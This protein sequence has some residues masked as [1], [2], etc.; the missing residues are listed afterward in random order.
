MSFAQGPPSFIVLAVV[1]ASAFF[2]GYLSADYAQAIG[3]L[4]LSQTTCL[5][6]D[7]ELLFGMP[8]PISGLPENL[9]AFFLFAFVV[10]FMFGI[11]ACLAG[12][13]LG[14]R[15]ETKLAFQKWREHKNQDSKDSPDKTLL[16]SPP[17][18]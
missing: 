4:F 17:T 15:R 2:T 3:A 11:V 16:N 8:S 12:A 18:A 7:A 13:F 10:F 5:V 6:L 9:Q 1:I 14:D